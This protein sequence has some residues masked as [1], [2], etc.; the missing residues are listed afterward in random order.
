M[1]QHIDT[2]L[3][4]KH[5]IEEIGS[6][7]GR[8]LQPNVCHAFLQ[9]PRHFFI[10]HTYR[11]RG[12]SLTWDLVTAPALEEIYCDQPLVTKIDAQGRPVCS[13]SQPSLMALQLE[14]LDVRYGHVALEIGTGTGYNAVLMSHLVGHTSQVTSLDIDEELV[15]MAQHHLDQTEVKNVLLVQGDD[16]AGY[17]LHSPYDRLLITCGVISIPRL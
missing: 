10:E 11:Q 17:D 2:H 1:L 5:F 6:R 12:N 15:S 3:Y 4:Q 16:F 7:L 9:I 14:A 13:S 8:P